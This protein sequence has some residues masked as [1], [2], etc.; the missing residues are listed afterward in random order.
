[1]PSMPVFGRSLLYAHGHCGANLGPFDGFDDFLVEPVVA[2]GTVVTLD[3]GVLLWSAGL[4][5]LYGNPLFLSVGH[6]Q[7]RASVTQSKTK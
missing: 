1:M 4:N 7:E 5:V 3:I 2:H 6:V